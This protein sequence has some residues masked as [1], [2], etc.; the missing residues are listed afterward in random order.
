MGQLYQDAMEMVREL[1]KPSLSITI[2]ATNNWKEIQQH[3][4]PEK[5]AADRH[6]IATRASSIPKTVE[7]INAIVSAEIPVQEAEPELYNLVTTIMLHGSF[8]NSHQCRG[9]FCFR[10]NYPQSL[11][12]TTTFQDDSY[13]ANHRTA[14]ASV[15]LHGYTFINRNIVP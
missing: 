12:E 14:G 6:D 2:T 1:G 10:Y 13:P 11:I 8:N 9:K 15:E 5:L 4:K 7:T 3:L